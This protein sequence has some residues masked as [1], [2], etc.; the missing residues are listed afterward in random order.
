MNI[1]Q[2]PGKNSPNYT[3]TLTF[4]PEILRVTAYISL[5]FMLLVGVI[6]TKKWVEVEPT[7]TVIYQL[8]GFNHICNVLD[9]EPS[10]TISAML[11]PFWEIPFVLY[12]I[13]NFL[14]IQDAYREGNAPR[15]IFLVAATFLPVELLLTIWFRLVLVRPPITEDLFF[16][17]YLPYLGFQLLLCLVAFENVLYFYAVK[18]LPFNNNRSLAIAYL[19]LLFLVTSACISVGLSVAMG[20]PILDLTGNETQRTIFRAIAS[21]YMILSIPAPLCLSFLEMRRSPKHTLS[22]E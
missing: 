12:L 13:F 5:I 1:D 6:V 14:R 15:S 10:R 9:H 4:N 11:L 3:F 20:H 7:T 16:G 8:F 21:V 2:S 19:I 17:H 22:F 18:A